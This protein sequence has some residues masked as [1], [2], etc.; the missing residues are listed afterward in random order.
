MCTYKVMVKVVLSSGQDTD[1][2]C[3]ISQTIY[4]C[5]FS[6]S[7]PQF[8]CILC[9][10]YLAKEKLLVITIITYTNLNKNDKSKVY[11]MFFNFKGW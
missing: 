6:W 4:I 5:Q 3:T 8:F 2:T 9:F 1:A 11:G 10:C 7:S